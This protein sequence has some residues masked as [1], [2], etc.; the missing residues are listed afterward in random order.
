M[1]IESDTPHTDCGG[2]GIASVQ[3]T[4]LRFNVLVRTLEAEVNVV[5]NTSFRQLRSFDNVQRMVDCTSKGG[6]ERL[7]HVEVAS[8][9]TW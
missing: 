2:A 4:Q 3:G 7:I 9:C 6:I 1:A 5:V 8:R